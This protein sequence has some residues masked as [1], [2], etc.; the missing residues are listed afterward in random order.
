MSNKGFSDE[1]LKKYA[2]V[3]KINRHQQE[4][5]GK[6]VTELEKET[7]NLSNITD[8]NSRMLDELLLQAESLDKE[9]LSQISK[10]DVNNALKITKEDQILIDKNS[11]VYNKIDAVEF[12]SNWDEF[13]ENNY[14]YAQKYNISLNEDPFEEL[15][16]EE[17]KSRIIAKVRDQ[18]NL[19]PLKLD[20]YD[21]LFASLSGILSGL[22]DV[23]LIGEPLKAKKQRLRSMKGYNKEQLAA[24]ED[25][26][27]NKHVHKKVDNIIMKFTDFVY[28]YDKKHDLLVKNTRKK[29]DSVAG[30]IGY[31][32]ERFKVPY[33]ARYAKDLGVSSED[34]NMNPKNHHLK[35]LAHQPDII[36]LFFSILDQF[37]DTTS[38]VEQGKIKIIKN[39]QKENKIELRGSDFLSKILCGV[40]NWLGHLM[41]D[42]GGSSGTR[43]HENKI[44]A[45]IPMPFYELTQLITL[46]VKDKDG[47]PVTF[48]KIAE[49]AYTNGYDFRFGVTLAIPVVLNELFIRVFWCIKEVFY[50]QRPLKE[51]L[52]I[53]TSREIDRLLLVGHGALCAVDGIDAFIR[54]GGGQNLVFMLS[55]MN[56]VAWTRFGIAAFKETVNI[57]SDLSNLKKLDEDLEKE[58][59]RM[60]T[61]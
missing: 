25:S 18:Y 53:N 41:S 3:L 45:G 50:H 26:K 7:S 56:L 22:I 57:Y 1:E 36:G 43:G 19:A 32:E 13:L 40:L 2:N 52:K 28:E 34:L 17:E 37:L 39:P 12:G 55:R 59:K 47:I 60:V 33:D 61:N 48:A 23:F 42:I 49:H 21:Y 46:K 20:K 31:L 16:T 11:K 10:A 58:W 27:L 14:D 9:A 54:S 8:N 35:S 30:A 29:Y 4:N 51:I 6:R 38:V 5:V 24:L 15:L 44:G